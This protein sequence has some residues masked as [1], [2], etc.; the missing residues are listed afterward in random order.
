MRTKLKKR[1]L[2]VVFSTNPII[3]AL[4][5]F[6]T[7]QSTKDYYLANL[8]FPPKVSEVLGKT[9]PRY[10]RLI[11]SRTPKLIFEYKDGAKKLIVNT[12]LP[13]TEIRT[14]PRPY[15]AFARS[16]FSAIDPSLNYNSFVDVGCSSGLLISAI[17]ETNRN[18]KVLGIDAFDF[19]KNSAPKNIIQNIEV[20][21]LRENLADLGK[22]DICLSTEV[23]EHIEPAS[24]GAYLDNLYN[25]TGKTLILTWSR[26]YPGPDAPP[27][28]LSVLSKR[29]I[30][31]LFQAWGFRYDKKTTKKFLKAARSE[32]F[33][34]NHWADTLTV[35]QK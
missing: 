32:E 24:L 7:G 3:Q 5:S 34:Y 33:F 17:K 9:S 26:T 6:L 2:G 35:W 4:N 31:I 29:Q 30:K 22:F 28:H 11:L 19:L 1:I 16:L 13:E 15:E 18:A 10:D 14:D 23:G 8:T 12:Y 27:Q 21:D 20:R 25:L